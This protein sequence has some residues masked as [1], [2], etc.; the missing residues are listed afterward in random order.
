MYATE[1]M[2]VS[3]RDKLRSM[4]HYEISQVNKV[5]QFMTLYVHIFRFEL[6]CT[7]V[8]LEINFYFTELFKKDNG[9]EGCNHFYFKLCLRNLKTVHYNFYKIT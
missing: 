7:F 2:L 4:K 9:L 5:I 6:N 8:Y 3:V 1:V